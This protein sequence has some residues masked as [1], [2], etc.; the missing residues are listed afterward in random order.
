MVTGATSITST[1]FVGALT[2]AASSNLLKAGGTMTGHTL[3]GDNVSAKFGAGDDLVINHDGSNSYVE[4]SGTGGL[5]LKAS[6]ITLQ[7]ASNEEFI[8]CTS[9]GAVDLSFG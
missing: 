4:D 5:I 6:A 3:H 2:G 1:A 9:D 7:S 8:V